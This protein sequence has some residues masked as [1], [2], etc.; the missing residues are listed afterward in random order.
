MKKLILTAFI[1]LAV[2]T[3]AYAQAGRGFKGEVTV[4]T[5]DQAVELAK[6][7]A[8]SL[9]GY[10]INSAEEVPVR[11]GKAYKVSATDGM[12]NQMYFFIN[13]FGA[14]FG[15]ITEAT[16]K[17]IGF[18]DNKKGYAFGCPQGKKGGKRFQQQGE[19]IVVTAEQAKN[20]AEKYLQGLK[21]FSIDSVDS[22]SNKSGRYISYR[23]YIKDGSSNTFY[24]HVNPWGN[25]SGLMSYTRT[26]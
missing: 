7:K 26:K 1:V 9:K 25:I 12:K 18:C 23:V 24:L 10:T 6:E 19:P 17:D 16:A 11:R 8:A 3:F 2:G 15:P 13:P 4:K 14:V 22:Y 21:G 5:A 20:A